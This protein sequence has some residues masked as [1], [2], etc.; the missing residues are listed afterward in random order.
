MSIEQRPCIGMEMHLNQRG[1]VLFLVLLKANSSLYWLMA[2]MLDNADMKY[3]LSQLKVLLRCDS[4]LN[5]QSCGDIGN[6][7]ALDRRGSRRQTLRK[8]S[9]P[10]TSRLRGQTSSK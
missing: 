5:H 10:L 3:F 6:F 4:W 9:P 1:E 2:T 7:A 8:L